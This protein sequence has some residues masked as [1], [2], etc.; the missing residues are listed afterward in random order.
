M[1]KLW[2]IFIL[3]AS[4]IFISGCTSE[5]KTDISTEDERQI[6]QQM[7]VE[8]DIPL[9]NVKQ[10]DVPDIYDIWG[11]KVNPKD[12]IVVSKMAV[13]FTEPPNRVPPVRLVREGLIDIEVDF[14]GIDM[15][16]PFEVT[17]VNKIPDRSK[18]LTFLRAR[19]YDQKG[20]VMMCIKPLSSEKIDHPP[21]VQLAYSGMSYSFCDVD[22][23]NLGQIKEWEF[24]IY[25]VDI[26]MLPTPEPQKTVNI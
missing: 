16:F 21:D 4:I 22:H 12:I 9:S 8:T 18:K 14:K 10:G 17:K 20:N 6:S 19:L 11:N 24:F 23:E 1:K 2:I 25:F 5:E 26:N 15:L 3:I 7:P 13:G